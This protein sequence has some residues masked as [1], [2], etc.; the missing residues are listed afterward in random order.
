MFGISAFFTNDNFFAAKVYIRT[1]IHTIGALKKCLNILR[2]VAHNINVCLGQG[3]AIVRERQTRCVDGDRVAADIANSK[4]S[5]IDICRS[6][7]IGS[8]K[9]TTNTDFFIYRNIRWRCREI[10]RHGVLGRV[11]NHGI[12]GCIHLGFVVI[13]AQ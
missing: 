8:G 4:L 6:H 1:L 5:T 7:G 12:T 3:E 2:L 13:N 11:E 10:N 9:L